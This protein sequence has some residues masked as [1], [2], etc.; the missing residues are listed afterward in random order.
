M[1][2]Y[3]SEATPLLSGYLLGEDHVKGYATALDVHHGDGHVILLG[4]RPQWRAQPF[5]NFRIL[6][7]AVL[8][9]R[10]VAAAVT[11]NTDFW[12]APDE[13]EDD[14]EGDDEAPEEG[15]GRRGGGPG[16]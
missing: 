11:P 10:A 6:F 8:Y 3:N 16:R 15:G 7:N 12:E 4:M 1:A 2:K 5:D 13:D 14:D 9:S